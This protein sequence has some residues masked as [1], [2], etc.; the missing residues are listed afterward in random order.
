MIPTSREE[1]KEYCLRKLGAPV[2]KINVSDAQI[3]DRIDEALQFYAEHH[4]NG[5]QRAYLDIELTERDIETRCVTVPDNVI[6]VTRILDTGAGGFN[7]S[8]LF[9]VERD[10]MIQ[11]WRNYQSGGM[12]S[13]HLMR[14]SM[15]TMKELM[16]ARPIIRFNR[17]TN[18]L[19]IDIT[20]DLFKPGSHVVI[21]C[22]MILDGDCYPDIW[23]ERILQNYATALI[24]EAWGSILSKFP[25]LQLIGG[26]QFSGDMIYQ[27]AVDERKAIEETIISQ[28]SA[29]PLDFYG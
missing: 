17:H 2:I 28:Y 24:K 23:S 13:Y 21:E 8:P 7:S 27:Q 14:L 10:M 26:V 19:H 18:K 16:V 5:T 6:S 11:G 20:K 1:F 4:Y 9:N 25:N 3:D 15:E 29:I 12:T 22:H